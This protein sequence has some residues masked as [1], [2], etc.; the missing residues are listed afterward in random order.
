MDSYYN[1]LFNTP[2][3]LKF[4]ESKKKFQPRFFK[5]PSSLYRDGENYLSKKLEFDRDM[6]LK[7]SNS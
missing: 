5:K 2:K 1:P 7:I 6:Y 3:V 4:E